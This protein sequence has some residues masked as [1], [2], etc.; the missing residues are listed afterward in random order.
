MVVVS[1]STP[2]A[3]KRQSVRVTGTV[4][5]FDRAMVV[6]EVGFELRQ[7]YYG[8]YRNKPAIVATPVEQIAGEEE[9]Q[10]AWRTPTTCR[11]QRVSKPLNARVLTVRFWP[12]ERSF[13]RRTPYIVETAT[14]VAVVRVSIYPLLPL[15]LE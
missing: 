12:A 2:D 9:K 15:I 5:Q 4:R 13:T 8:G 6:E 14:S 7:R 11:R 1:K 3:P 10:R